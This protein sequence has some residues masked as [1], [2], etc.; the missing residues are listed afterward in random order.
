MVTPFGGTVFGV[1]RVTLT[2][3]FMQVCNNIHGSHKW[4]GRSKEQAV[5]D[6][7]D[8]L[9]EKRSNSANGKRGKNEFPQRSI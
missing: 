6:R 7:D 2:A 4:S 5:G 1:T 3:L 8:N 9:D